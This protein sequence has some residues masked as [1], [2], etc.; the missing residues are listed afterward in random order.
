[1]LAPDQVTESNW[2][3][4]QA[5]GRAIARLDHKNIVK[6]YNMGVDGKDGRECPYYV[7]DL[8]EGISLADCIAEGTRAVGQ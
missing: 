3:R 4:F 2:Q 8:L 7:M 5:E 6:I 1:M